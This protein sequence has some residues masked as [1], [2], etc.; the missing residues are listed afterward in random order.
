MT[1][2]AHI[3][4][5]AYPYLSL[6]QVNLQSSV[7]VTKVVHTFDIWCCG[8]SQFRKNIDIYVSRY[9]IYFANALYPATSCHASPTDDVLP[10]TTTYECDQPTYGK[11]VHLR[12]AT[13]SDFGVAELAVFVEM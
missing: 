8:G 13:K 11:Y 9:N 5:I 12:S 2:Q 1:H 3:E 7:W 4:H 6:F 10:I